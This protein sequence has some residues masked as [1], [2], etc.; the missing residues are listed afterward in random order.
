VGGEVVRQAAAAL[1]G[2]VVGDQ[3]A[4]PRPGALGDLA[5]V[6]RRPP[7]ARTELLAV[8][9]QRDLAGEHEPLVGGQ[10]VGE[11]AQAADIVAVGQVAGHVGGGIRDGGKRGPFVSCLLVVGLA[12]G[13]VRGGLDRAASTKGAPAIADA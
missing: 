10:L 3:H 4:Q 9:I 11:L 5:E 12:Q 13:S 6:L 1:R 7:E 2:L 8:H